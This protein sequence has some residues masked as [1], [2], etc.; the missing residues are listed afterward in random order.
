MNGLLSI[1]LFILISITCY[2][3]NK[4]LSNPEPYFTAIIVSNIDTAIYWYSDKLGFEVLNRVDLV[5]R[6][7]KQAN[8]KCGNTLIE[9]I[10]S[11]TSIYPKDILAGKPKTTQLAGYFKFGFMVED[12]DDW[13]NHLMESGAEFHGRV[14]KDQATGKKIVIIKDPDGNRIQLFER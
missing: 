13:I 5:E 11:N 1:S 9:L 8:L 3:Q 2:S 12:F 10:E 14:V 4:K 6:G 7:I